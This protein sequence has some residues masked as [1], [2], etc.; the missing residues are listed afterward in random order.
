[1]QWLHTSLGITTWWHWIGSAHERVQFPL[2]ACLWCCFCWPTMVSCANLACTMNILLLLIFVHWWVHF[3][4][5]CIVRLGV[6]Q[7]F[8]LL[9]CSFLVQSLGFY[10]YNIAQLNHVSTWKR[11]S[12]GSLLRIEVFTLQTIVCVCPLQT[13]SVISK[14]LQNRAAVTIITWYIVILLYVQHSLTLDPSRHRLWLAMLQ[15][16]ASMSKLA[17]YVMITAYNTCALHLYYVTVYR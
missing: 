12:T 9:I 13:A 16:W 15:L 5:V 3:A 2:E 1:M 17:F 8:A 14:S 4:K 7:R 6:L 10:V 11:S